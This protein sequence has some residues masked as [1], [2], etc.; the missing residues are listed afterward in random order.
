MARMRSSPRT[1]NP[2]R[3]SYERI[4]V[5]PPLSKDGWYVVSRAGFVEIE[6]TGLGKRSMDP[7]LP[8]PPCCRS[9]YASGIASRHVML[10]LMES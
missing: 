5:D 1:D 4:P 2:P 3:V 7:S 9:Q 10:E 8:Q 6:Q